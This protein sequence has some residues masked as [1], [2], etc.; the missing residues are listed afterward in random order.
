MED[1]E[2]RDC[3][4]RRTGQ[5]DLVKIEERIKSLEKRV[6]DLDHCVE[7]LSGRI[8]Q[9]ELKPGLNF[10]GGGEQLPMR[11]A[12]KPM[13]PLQE[14]CVDASLAIDGF[15]AQVEALVRWA[16][17]AL[18]EM[19]QGGYVTRIRRAEGAAVLKPFE[20]IK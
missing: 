5:V 9:Q 7:L 13:T 15:T 19:D 20:A 17:A 3:E 16:R 12:G 11:P 8:A 14:A 2:R 18:D 10:V 6:H 4:G 1:V